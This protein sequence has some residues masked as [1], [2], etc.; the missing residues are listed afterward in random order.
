[1]DK[2]LWHREDNLRLE[3]FA[4]NSSGELYGR[5]KISVYGFGNAKSMF[6]QNQENSEEKVR[7]MAETGDLGLDYL[8]KKYIRKLHIRAFLP[9]F[10]AIDVFVGCDG[11]TWEKAATLRGEDRISVHSIP[12]VTMRNDIFRVRMEGYGAC[13]VYSMAWEIERGSDKK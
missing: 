4:Y 9:L 13:I 7:W 8:E 2:G 5:N 12:I 3:E 1:M 11:K 6:G 10:S